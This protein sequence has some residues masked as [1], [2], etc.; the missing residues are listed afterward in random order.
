M[1]ASAKFNIPEYIN[2]VIYTKLPDPLWDPIGELLAL[3]TGN[4]SH[5]PCRDNYLRAP[6]IVHKD[7]YSPLACSKR[8]PKAFTDRTLIHE[9]SYPEYYYRNNRQIFIVRK[10][11]A[12]D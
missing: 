11:G 6:Y 4:M 2:E 10:P 3:V 5:G 8:F 1:R 9:D 12:W 7:A